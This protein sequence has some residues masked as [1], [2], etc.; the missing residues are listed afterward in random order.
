MTKTTCDLCESEIIGEPIR[1]EMR[2]GEHP[3]NGS[4]MTKTVDCCDICIAKI[5]NLKTN[6]EFDDIKSKF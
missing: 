3:H 2:D 1:V 4:T 5:P 6:C